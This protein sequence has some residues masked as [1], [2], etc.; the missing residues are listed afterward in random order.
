MADVALTNYEINQQAYGNIPA[1]SE[2]RITES[3]K[4]IL[5]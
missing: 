5:D 4:P 3:L 1:L 2:E